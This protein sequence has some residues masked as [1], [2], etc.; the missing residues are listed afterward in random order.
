MEKSFQGN[1]AEKGVVYQ[2]E[3]VSKDLSSDSSP[4]DILPMLTF[5]RE[6][7]SKNQEPPNGHSFVGLF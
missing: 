5:I 3:S 2:F 7:L 6:F 1:E 4:R